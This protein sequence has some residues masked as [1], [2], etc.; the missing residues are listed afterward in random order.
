MPSLVA[1]VVAVAFLLALA[2]A[3]AW[4]SFLLARKLWR[5]LQ[6]P[7]FAAFGIWIA[8]TFALAVGATLT[9]VHHAIALPAGAQFSERFLITWTLEWGGSMVVTA[10]VGGV[11]VFRRSTAWQPVLTWPWLVGVAVGLGYMIGLSGQMDSGSKLCDAPA[12]GSCDDAWGL[13]AWVVGVLAAVVLG[14]TFVATAS[15]TR[16]LHPARWVSCLDGRRKT[17]PRD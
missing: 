13:G 2:G 11:V 5:R 3:T 7:E 8:V 16:I 10:F 15:L 12:G 6:R 9:I 17:R 1:L 4:G 14:G